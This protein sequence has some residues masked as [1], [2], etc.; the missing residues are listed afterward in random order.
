MKDISNKVSENSKLAQDVQKTYFDK[1]QDKKLSELPELKVGDAVLRYDKCRK[2]KKNGGLK[3]AWIGPY[4]I[5]KICKAGNYK[6]S[7]G[8]G[9]ILPGAY[10]RELIKKHQ[11]KRK[12]FKSHS[13]LLANLSVSLLYSC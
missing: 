8:E 7:S 13:L 4:K 2:R 12:S 10:K 5:A 6:L 1:K 9:N 3:L 11:D